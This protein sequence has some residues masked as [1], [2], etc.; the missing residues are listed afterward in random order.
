[1]VGTHAHSQYWHF[2][3]IEWW[4]LASLWLASEIAAP[5][6]MLVD[7][8]CAFWWRVREP[9]ARNLD[10]PGLLADYLWCRLSLPACA[11]SSPGDGKEAS[12]AMV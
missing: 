6:R 5:P 9:L 12:A 2:P 1:M 10:Q 7:F 8:P 11:V 3:R 4:N